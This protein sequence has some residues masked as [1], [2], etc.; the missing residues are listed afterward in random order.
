LLNHPFSGKAQRTTARGNE[1]TVYVLPE[2]EEE[3]AVT[4]PPPPAVVKETTTT[5]LEEVSTKRATKKAQNFVTEEMMFIRN[6]CSR[7]SSLLA[8]RYVEIAKSSW[9]LG[10]SPEELSSRMCM[11]L[12]EPKEE[13][14]RRVVE[15]LGSSE[16][17]SYLR[18]AL[19]V[20]EAG[21]LWY[22]DKSRKR[23]LGGVFW[24]ILQKGI[25]KEDMK[26]ITAEERKLKNRRRNQLKT[27][28]QTGRVRSMPR[29]RG[30]RSRENQRAER[31]NQHRRPLSSAKV[32]LERRRVATKE[33]QRR[34]RHER[35]FRGRTPSGKIAGGNEGACE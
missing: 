33:R 19:S 13:K 22:A 6:A 30:G 25:S 18:K 3:V 35:R 15:R 17:V 21:G 32:G 16:A 7:T 8:K 1:N 24:R 10:I 12:D 9:G 29:D 14:M 26:F 28:D 34:D 2:F 31:H 20:Q 11:L 4:P 27:R 5:E 23:S